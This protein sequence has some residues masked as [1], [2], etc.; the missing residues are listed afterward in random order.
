[1]IKL[2]RNRFQ[3]G[4]SEGYALFDAWEYSM[5]WKEKL[6][7]QNCNIADSFFSCPEKDLI[8]SAWR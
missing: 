3:K 6:F 2:E 8:I 7:L 5:G 1:M 4:Y